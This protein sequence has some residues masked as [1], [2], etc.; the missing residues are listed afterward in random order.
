MSDPRFDSEFFSL[1]FPH[2]SRYLVWPDWYHFW[3]YLIFPTYGRR[4]HFV[5]LI[6]L[7]HIFRYLE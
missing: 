4:L 1:S 7:S 2:I 3:K 5:V 6:D